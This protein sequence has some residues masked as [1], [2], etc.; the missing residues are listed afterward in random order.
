MDGVD[1]ERVKSMVRF[2]LL[3]I[4]SSVLLG[5]R[6]YDYRIRCRNYNQEARL[7]GKSHP[8]RT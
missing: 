2:C 8:S 7:D 3:L 5:I 6:R 4:Y 1:D